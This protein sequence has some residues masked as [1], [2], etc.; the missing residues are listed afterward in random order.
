MLRRKTVKIYSTKN[1][2][3]TIE[4]QCKIPLVKQKHLH[5][6][7]LKRAIE[8]FSSDGSETQN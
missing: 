5:S 8:W 6:L 2:L 7:M 3:N 1:L 4:E